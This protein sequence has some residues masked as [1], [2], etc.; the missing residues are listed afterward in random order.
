MEE[1]KYED[2]EPFF[3]FWKPEKENDF[4]VGVYQAMKTEF[5][6]NKSNVYILK[7]EN[8][9]S[10]GVWGSKVL[11]G[12]MDF[13]KTGD[14][15]KIIYLGEKSGKEQTYKDFNVQRVPQE[16]NTTEQ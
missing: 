8:G 14:D 3:E 13:C 5:G 2:V 10:I 11:D 15:L 9:D 12:K 1:K 6:K 16:E 4:V 7:Q